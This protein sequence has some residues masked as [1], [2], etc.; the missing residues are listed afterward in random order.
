M[1]HICIVCNTV[2]ER[3]GY[4][5][6]KYCSYNCYNR[7]RAKETAPCPVCGEVF[8]IEKHKS[9]APNKYCSSECRDTAR[10]QRTVVVCKQCG[11]EFMQKYRTDEN[12]CSNTCRKKWL[13]RNAIYK[14]CKWCNKTFA[15]NPTHR[16][17]CSLE[18]YGKA[19][20]ERKHFTRIEKELYAYLNSIGIKYEQQ[21][22]ITWKI[23]PDAYI[24]EFELCIYAD[25]AFWHRNRKDRDKEI[26][27]LIV[28]KGM[29]SLRLDEQKDNSLDLKPL[30]QFLLQN[31]NQ[32][33]S[34]AKS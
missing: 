23:R 8:I 27:N 16:Y 10:R 13:S 28:S 29:L 7:S 22:I 26:D 32:V 3:R 24:P 6:Y 17:F 9:R 4:R 25:G 2:F 30:Q 12:L 31:F 5:P 18:C 15:S 34:G 14:N 19:C 33:Y 11:K 1:K 21:P 20:L